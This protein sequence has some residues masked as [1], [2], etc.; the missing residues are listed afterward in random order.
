MH[1]L[2]SGLVS[3]H[4]ISARE[5]RKILSKTVSGNEGMKMLRRAEV[6]RVVIPAAHVR[7]WRSHAL[8]LPKGLEQ[9][10]FIEV[11]KKIVVRFKCSRSHPSRC[12]TSRDLKG[13]S[14]GTSA[15]GQG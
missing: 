9:R 8:A 4:R 15:P 13:E 6:I 1:L 2:L 12:R 10:V 5:P 14:G 11:Q 3:C 7:S